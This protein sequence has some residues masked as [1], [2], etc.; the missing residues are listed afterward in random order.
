MRLRH[1]AR[2]CVAVVM[3]AI[4]MQAHARATADGS[5]APPGYVATSWVGNTFGGA[6]DSWVQPGIQGLWVGSDGTA[7]G[8]TIWNEGA[9]ELR[10]YRDGQVFGGYTFQH[11]NDIPNGGMAVTGDAN[12]VYA[13]VRFGNTAGVMRY[14]RALNPAP[15]SGGRDPQGSVLIVNPTYEYLTAMAAANGKLYVADPRSYVSQTSTTPSESTVIKVYDT[16]NLQG[17]VQTSFAAPRAHGIAVDGAGDIW[18]LEVGNG[19][20]QPRIVRFTPSG[21]PTGQV[22]TT[23]SD[24]TAIAVDT[25]GGGVGRLLVT[26]DGRDQNVKIF[27]GLD[28][29]PVRTGTFGV[30][31]GVNAGPVAGRV[32][33]D[34]LNGPAAIGVD[35]TGNIY[36]VSNGTPSIAVQGYGQGAD[37]QAYKPDGSLLWEDYGQ[38]YNTMASIDPATG[39]D[40]YTAFDHYSL[41]LTKPVGQQWTR[42]GWTLNKYRYP[43]DPRINGQN[44]GQLPANPVV[45]TI[46]GHKLLFMGNGMNDALNIFRFRP[47]SETAI[48]AAS[49][50][51]HQA[52]GS[53]TAGEFIWRDANGDGSPY[54]DP[55]EY[56]SPASQASVNVTGWYVDSAGDVW[57]TIRDAG[58]REFPFG[59]FDTHGNPIYSY[60]TMRTFPA[61]AP[62]NDP[63]RLSYDPATDTLVLTGY[64][65]M[66]E[67]PNWVQG[68]YKFAGSTLALYPNFTKTASP[69]ASWTTVLPYTQSASDAVHKPITLAVAGD[70]AFV[71]YFTGANNQLNSEVDI[72]SLATGAAAGILTPGSAVGGRSG[73][74]DME[75]GTSAYETPGGAYLVFS[76]DDGWDKTLMYEWAPNATQ[77]P[78]TKVV[79]KLAKGGDRH[80]RRPHRQARH[81]HAAHR[82][83]DHRHNH[84]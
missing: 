19:S 70:Y 13:A 64:T 30:Q 25:S 37:L 33:P 67:T 72:F 5:A 32:G 27:G 52:K 60:Q 65:S 16:G 50:D 74:I 38:K 80:V 9:R 42:V 17:G 24:P 18:V 81:R 3:I 75:D 4:T 21:K 53:P 55:S 6:N 78:A 14:D 63:R 73:N 44:E 57:Q 62:F 7:Y 39:V 84:R 31:G 56:S 47:P 54:G 15:F 10:G 20:V 58:I 48:P 51:I 11:D 26:D 82:S 77:A 22:I 1:V 71:G 83:K 41:D 28:T 59:G 79:V 45:R 35:A 46:R 23:V 49:I 12:Y 36:I 68:D 40:V 76:E 2:V 8:E 43:Y 66:H 61:P 34:R 29:K 69:K